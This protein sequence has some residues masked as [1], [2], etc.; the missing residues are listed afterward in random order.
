MGTQF[1]RQCVSRREVVATTQQQQQQQQHQIVY[2][3]VIIFVRNHWIWWWWW[4]WE[5]EREKATAQR[6]FRTQSELNATTNTFLLLLLIYCYAHQEYFF[7][8]SSTLKLFSQ[9]GFFK[10]EKFVT[11]DQHSVVLFEIS[12][13]GPSSKVL[14]LQTIAARLHVFV[15]REPTNIFHSFLHCWVGKFGTQ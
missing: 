9:T 15:L 11:V 5:R 7:Y 8:I 4:W 6:L 1:K 14:Q 3:F 2:S 10:K 12:S 13:L